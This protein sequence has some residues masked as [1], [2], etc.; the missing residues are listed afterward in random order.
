MSPLD[1]R[2]MDANAEALG[3]SVTELMGNAGRAVADYLGKRYPGKRILFVC[4]PGNNG[5]D[6][7]A[8]ASLMDPALV[9][10]ALLRKPSDIHTDA[11]WHFYSGLGC[12]IIDY[13]KVDLDAYDVIVDCALGTGMK[14]NVREP[15]R[16]FI[17]AS[18]GIPEVVSVDVPSG[19]GSDVSVHPKATVTFHDLKE[20]MVLEGTVRNVVAYGAYV[21]LGIHKD[22]LLHVSEMSDRSRRVDPSKLVH[23]GQILKVKVI[24]VDLQRNRIS[25]S[26]KG[27]GGQGK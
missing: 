5:G 6:G 8:A 9:S 25:L 12:P 20:G 11:A 1:S 23:I 3:T 10:V 2:V 17:V 24:G 14:G 18:H 13:S 7:F 27:L 4:G 15:Y 26:I 16:S 19:L 22:G 21:D